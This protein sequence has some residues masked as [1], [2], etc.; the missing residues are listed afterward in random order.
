MQIAK[1]L[2]TIPYIYGLFI[3]RIGDKRA[4]RDRFDSKCFTVFDLTPFPARWG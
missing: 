4:I 1:K 3:I 2:N